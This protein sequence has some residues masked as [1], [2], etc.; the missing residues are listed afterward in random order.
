[1]PGR[2]GVFVFILL[3]TVFGTAVLFAALR[4]R[5]PAEPTGTGLVL[6]WD[7]PFVLEEGD[8]PHRGLGFP[9][10]GTRGPYLHEVVSALDRAA[11]DDRVS[12]V[13]LRIDYMAWGWAKATDV[14]DALHRFRA[15]GKPVIASL[16]GGGDLEYY[17][18]SASDVVASPPEARL[19]ID[20]LTASASFFRGTLDKLDVSP[21]FVQAG[22]YKTGAEQYT[23]TDLSEASRVAMGAMLD[24][25]YRGLVDS[26]AAARGFASDEVARLLDAG[27]FSAGEALDAGLVDTLIYDADVDSFTIQVAEGA[28]TTL[29]FEDYVGRTPRGRGAVALIHASGTILPGRSGEAPGEERVLGAESMIEALR[30]ARGR[31]GISAVVLRIDSPGG[32]IQASD[33]IWAEVQ[34][35]S[36]VKPLIVSMS[37]VAASGGYYIAVPARYIVAQPGTITGSI[38][39]YGG[40]FNIRGLLDKLGIGIETLSRGAHAGVLSTFRDFTPD[41][42]RRFQAQTDASYQVFLEKVARGRRLDLAEVDSVGQGRVWTGVAAWQRG[43]VDT[44]GGLSTALALARQSAGLDPDAAVEVI[45]RVERHWLETLLESAFDERSAATDPLGLQDGLAALPVGP[46]VRAALVASRIQGGVL[47]AMMPWSL[48]VR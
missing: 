39:V 38:G 14:R 27:P 47:L 45:P 5:G 25:L 40:K 18:A 8:V 7:V 32:S 13:V 48:E 2:R 31:A 3:L 23:R 42:L 22:V 34:R 16:T 29:D 41:E 15:S 6:V 26:L 37:D 20:G 30:E 11:R 46:A 19:W 43:L 10:T 21:N 24:D 9:W 28:E 35:L 12:A 36:E 33:D 17:V 4:L 44:L 1:M